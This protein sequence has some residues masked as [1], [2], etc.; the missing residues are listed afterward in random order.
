MQTNSWAVAQR[1]KSRVRDVVVHKA[2]FDGRV[3]G[4]TK[5]TPANPV[6]ATRI[7]RLPRPSWL[8]ESQWPFQTSLFEANGL[9]VAV[10]EVG[11]GPVLL[12]V[13]T[14][15]WSFIWRE[16]MIRLSADFRCICLDAP[17]TGQSPRVPSSEINLENSSRAVE[18]VIRG[19]DLQDIA[20]VVHDLGGP[21][22]I[23]AA[24]RTP[25]RIRGI[26]AVNAFGWRPSGAKFRG[27]LNVVGSAFV[28]EFDVLTEF[29]PKLS[30][31]AF[32]IGRHLD[33]QSRNVFRA[34][35]KQGRVRAFHYYIKDALNCESLYAELAKAF[36]GPFRGLPFMTIF[37]E[38]NDPLGFQ[39][40]WKELFPHARQVVIAKGNHYPMGDDPDLVANSIRAWHRDSV[41]PRT[42]R[43]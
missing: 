33:E 19:L 38:R 6:L 18:A 5:G 11:K 24:A 41:M 10:T 42:T 34:G 17:G 27:M 16:V 35:M 7:T 4:L 13:H 32:G 23:A 30:A 8:P 9:S 28:R 21:A 3:L 31:S 2:S 37:G 39:P 36:A 14:G 22:G 40:R 25:E 29:V 43:Q 20:L 15:Q 26:A 12:F 1:I